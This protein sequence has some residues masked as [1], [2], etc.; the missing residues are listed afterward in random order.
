M[1]TRTWQILWL[2]HLAEFED[3]FKSD[4]FAWYRDVDAT[5]LVVEDGEHVAEFADRVEETVSNRAFDLVVVE[6]DQATPQVL[7][8]L[9][10]AGPALPVL[11]IAGPDQGEQIVEAYDL[12]VDGYVTRTDDEEVFRKL[13]AKQV[14]EHLSRDLDPPST[15]R[16]S[17][18]E[19][20]RYSHYYNVLHPFFVIDIDRR[21]RYVNQA[22]REFIREAV[23]GEAELPVGDH[24]DSLPLRVI[25]PELQSVLR[26]VF[27]GDEVIRERHFEELTGETGLREMFYRPVVVEAGDVAAVS[28][29]IYIPMH[30]EL[31][32]ARRHAAL[33]RL[34]ASVAHD[35]NNLLSVFATTAA[36]WRGELDQLGDDQRSRLGDQLEMIDQTVQKGRRLTSN[37]L[38]Y[39]GQSRV[40]RETFSLV[41]F[42]ESNRDFVQSLVGEDIDLTFDLDPVTPPRRG[43]P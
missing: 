11:L 14:F 4:L 23:G 36:V 7:R 40:D 24:L 18:S 29:S 35:F 27:G 32:E 21:L 8:K 13:L 2:G 30:P 22:G 41:E 1:S 3:I 25:D 6:S 28:V 31:R 9:R 33:G 10:N 26:Q 43:R 5:R 20:L 15:R 16:P 12:G 17:A 42:L 39:T 38:S 34:A 19:L 37:L